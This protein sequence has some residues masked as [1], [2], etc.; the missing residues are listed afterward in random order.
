ML[1]GVIIKK[2]I[3]IVRNAYIKLTAE[4]SGP[5]GRSKNI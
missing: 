4:E 1:L 3:A 5:W 2:K